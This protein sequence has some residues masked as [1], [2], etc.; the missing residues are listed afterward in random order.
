MT[1]EEA[2]DNW[3]GD[4]KFPHPSYTIWEVTYITAINNYKRDSIAKNY[5]EV[6]Q[7]LGNWEMYGNLKLSRQ[8]WH[9]LKACLSR[10]LKL[11][12]K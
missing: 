5:Y 1:Y 6:S 4:T 12:Q 10:T 3:E 11:Y 7:K 2:R 9:H 8:E